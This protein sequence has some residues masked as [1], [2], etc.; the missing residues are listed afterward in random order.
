MKMAT[1]AGNTSATLLALCLAAT[2]TGCGLTQ[3][4][5]DG[6]VAA[7]KSIFYKQVKTLHMDIR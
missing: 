2:L 5:S 1:T 6:T 7:T 4:I 3:K